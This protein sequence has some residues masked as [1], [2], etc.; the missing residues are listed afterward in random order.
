MN[1]LAL[2]DVVVGYDGN[3]EPVLGI[4]HLHFPPGINIVTG[5][6]G[7]GKSTL[8]RALTSWYPGISCTGRLELDGLP[9]RRRRIG[10]VT[11][12]P[13]D[14]LVGS[15]SFISNLLLA[16]STGWEFLSP[17]LAQTRARKERL[18][19]VLEDLGVASMTTSLLDKSAAELSG[20]Q[21][22]LLAI[23]MRLLREPRLLLLD[24]CTANLDN[25]NTSLVMAAIARIAE[26]GCVVLFATHDA[27]L[28]KSLPTNNFE[29]RNATVINSSH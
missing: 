28:S 15:L 16:T 11:Q 10:L 18:L 17:A 4:S 19:A 1:G 5:G 2:E 23:G 21:Q 26:S 20:G 27:N 6:N 22:Q 3:A 8:L 9:L 29:V 14:S 12:R 25:E 24:E 13:A 7:T